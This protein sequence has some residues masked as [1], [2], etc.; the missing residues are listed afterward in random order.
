M[1]DDEPLDHAAVDR[2][3]ERL[4]ARTDDALHLDS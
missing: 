1:A 4:A 2:C 3:Y